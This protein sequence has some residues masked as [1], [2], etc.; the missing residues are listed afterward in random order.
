MDN[1]LG[2]VLE[3]EQRMKGVL[4]GK[5]GEVVKGREF[6]GL[7]EGRGFER[8][9]LMKVVEDAVGGVGTVEGCKDGGR[10]YEVSL[11]ERFKF[12]TRLSIVG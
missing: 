9:V 3:I 8:E 5:F 11:G 1:L 12:G 4:G 10:V 7:V 2:M 6:E